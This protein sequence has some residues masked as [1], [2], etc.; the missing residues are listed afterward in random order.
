MPGVSQAPKNCITMTLSRWRSRVLA[1]TTRAT[2]NRFSRN[3]ERAGTVW[4]ERLLRELDR[5]GSL[6]L[7]PFR[8]RRHSQ[9]PSRFGSTNQLFNGVMIGD[10]QVLE[11]NAGQCFVESQK[12]GLFLKNLEMLAECRNVSA[13]QWAAE[14]MLRSADKA[15]VGGLANDRVH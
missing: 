7:I 12:F 1:P 3:F 9:D 6:C 5:R 2:G 15:V 13:S 4:W 10:W 14:C 11:R 8:Y